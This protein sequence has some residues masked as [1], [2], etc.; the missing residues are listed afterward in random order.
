MDAAEIERGE[1]VSAN[2]FSVLG[3][4]PILGRIFSPADGGTTSSAPVAV[5]SYA[6]WRNRLG[7]NLDILDKP[8]RINGHEF[9]VIGVAPPGFSGT[10]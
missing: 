4:R 1:T 8:I 7:G 2:Y 6:L 3:V 9:T 5:M 10:F